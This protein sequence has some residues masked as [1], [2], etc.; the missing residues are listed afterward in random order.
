MT[1]CVVWGSVT[2]G[3]NQGLVYAYASSHVIGN[4][5]DQTNPAGRDCLYVRG[6][7][8]NTGRIANNICINRGTGAGANFV[9][10]S[11]YNNYCYSESGYGLAVGGNCYEVI[12][13]TAITNATNKEAMYSNANRTINN[14][15]INLNA[16]NT[17]P[18]L[19]VG[20]LSAVECYVYGNNSETNNASAYNMALTSTGLIYFA[21]NTMGKVGLGL[22]L[23]G[24]TNQMTN[25]PDAFGNVKIG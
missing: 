24:N 6:S 21:N 3:G 8:P 9:Y 5:L 15:A 7:G 13:N 11:G 23:N 22:N 19:T 18:A 2:I 12:G 14:T 20:K 25:T 4:Y 10:G 1:N 17:L 16:T